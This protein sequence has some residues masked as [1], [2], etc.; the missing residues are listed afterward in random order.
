VNRAHR[1][2]LPA[3]AVLLV[4][5]GLVA[6]TASAAPKGPKAPSSGIKTYSASV[7]P[8]VTALPPGVGAVV[9]LTLANA[10]ASTTGFSSAE[11]SFDAG[12]RFGVPS[13]DRPGWSVASLSSPGAT[14]TVLRLTSEVGSQYAVAP[15]SSVILTLPVS[16]TATPGSVA[17]TTRV[18]QS[19]D[20]SGTGNDFL[21][22]GADPVAYFGTGPAHTI[23]WAVEPSPV[24]V[25]A[26]SAPSGVTTTGFTPTHVMCPAIRVVDASGAP[27]TDT[28]VEVTVTASG[29][30]LTYTDP[31]GTQGFPVKRTTSAGV[32]RL[33]NQACTEGVRGTTLGTG[34]TMTA[35]ATVATA[36]RSISGGYAVL[37]VYGTCSGA[38]CSA[39]GVT[40]D[41]GT[42]ASVE[43]SGGSGSANRLTF[44]ALDYRAWTFPNDS[45]DP[46][47]GT[48][49]VNPY[50]D[51]VTVDLNG[52]AKTL[53]LRWTKKAVQWHTN[54]GAKNWQV[55]VATDY[56]WTGLTGPAVAYPEGATGDDV[57]WYVAAAPPCPTDL[58]TATGPCLQ[59]LGRNSGEQVAVVYLPNVDGDPRFV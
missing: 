20:F 37:P 40:G 13:V 6:P 33:G 45:C 29:G 35:T 1:R 18:K 17:F 12:G 9:G 31:N 23:A 38:S 19:N 15:G 8:A 41:K 27:V 10:A 34:L 44:Y 4:L 14:T 32:L 11:I 22:A 26:A 3:M 16:S 36:S 58:G 49:G 43:A 56:P 7:S 25:A 39:S 55:C 24:Q 28:D 46:D 47:P 52:Y 50:R 21:L 57:E 48:K 54:N 51:E 5:G 2:L 53:T 30:G 42:T 59:S